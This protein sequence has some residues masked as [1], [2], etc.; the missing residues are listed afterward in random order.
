M[1]DSLRVQWIAR[2]SRLHRRLGQVHRSDL[3]WRRK[4]SFFSYTILMLHALSL[5]H[6]HSLSLTYTHTHT[7]TH[8]LSLSFSHTHTLSFSLCVSLH[9]QFEC[10]HT[11]LSL[12]FR[13]D[14]EF[15]AWMQRFW[16]PWRDHKY[17]ICKNCIYIYI[18]REFI[19]NIDYAHWGGGKGPKGVKLNI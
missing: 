11:A 1:L 8:S 9:Q 3:G 7:R 15:A 12:A 14:E 18:E 17:Y 19:G 2:P 6:L 16:R 4:M 5:S 10:F 13:R